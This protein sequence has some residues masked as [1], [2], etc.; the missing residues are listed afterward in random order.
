MPNYFDYICEGS[1]NV[2][3][4][5]GD[6]DDNMSGI[7]YNEMDA[8]MCEFDSYVQEGVGLAIAAGVGGTALL[9]GLIALIAKCFGNSSP[10][11]AAKTAKEA[12]AAAK[13]AEAAGVPLPEGLKMPPAEAFKEMEA[14]TR[15]EIEMVND[16][17]KRM[18]GESKTS[19]ETEKKTEDVKYLPIPLTTV[20]SYDDFFERCKTAID[21]CEEINASQKDLKMTERKVN[22]AQKNGNGGVTSDKQNSIKQKQGK[23]AKLVTETS[24]VI[25]KACGAFANVVKTK[26]AK[27]EQLLKNIKNN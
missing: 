4:E 17:Y 3:G 14:K 19:S 7:Q 27:A 5:Y 10:S 23:A 1:T 15:R 9:A 20:K 2:N 13:A 18:M 8:T 24:N 16:E 12:L 26:G 11:S 21:V 25:I 6:P 22:K